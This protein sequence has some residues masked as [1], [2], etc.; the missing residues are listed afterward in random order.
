MKS[1]YDIIV[2]GS[3]S[4]G[5]GVALG[6]KTF[7]FDVLMVEKDENNIGGECLNSGCVPSKA[8][9]HV[10]ELFAKG[11]EAASYGLGDASGKADLQKVWEYVHG[12]QDMI[13][14]HESV[15]YLREKEGL[16]IEIGYAKFSGRKEIEV[17]GKKFS[18]K[19]ILVATGSRPRMINVDG[20]NKVNIYTNE[21]LFHMKELPENMLIIGGGPIGMEMGQSFAR[22]GSKVRVLEKHNRIMSKELPEVSTIVQERLEKDGIDFFLEHQLIN[23]PEANMA[24]L[25]D[26]SGNEKTIQCDAV[27]VGIGRTVSHEGLETEKAGIKLKDKK[28]EIDDKLRAK[29]NKNIVFA[30]D[31]AGNVLFSHGAE[32][33]TTVLLTNFFTPSPFKQKFNLDHFSW[34]TF[35]DPEVCTFGLSEDEIKDRGISYERIDHSFESDDRAI[36]SDYRYGKLILFLKK[37]WLNPRNGKILGGTVVAPGAGE[38]AQEL[39][40]ANQQGLGAGAIFNKTY[41]YPV[42]TRVHKMALVEKFSSSISPTIKKLMK[43]LYH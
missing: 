28:V 8:L 38:M 20:M 13:R 40:M 3:G 26:K 12:R 23:F 35:T 17:N 30:G 18:A 6:M 31:S 14:D 19:K 25:R 5:L 10:A 11:R 24:L 42:Q 29:D 33:H 41:P 36:T 37:N 22:L 2:I 15:E 43:F 9:I 21:N 32:L 39:I 4:G 1:K 34:C 7:G 16:D 27:L